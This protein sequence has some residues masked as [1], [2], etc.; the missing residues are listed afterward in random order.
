MMAIASTAAVQFDPDDISKVENVSDIEKPEFQ[1]LVNQLWRLREANKNLKYAYIMRRTSDIN[2]FEFIADADMLTA[3]E[4][5]IN[6]NGTIDPD[7]E[8]PMP[9]DPYDVTEY[10]ALRDESYYYP[11]ADRELYADQWGL[12]LAAYAPIK[13]G[14]E[15]T[16]AIIGIDVLVGDYLKLTQAT[17]LPFI[18]FVAFL[19]LLLTLLT[20]MLVRIYKERVEIMRELD[21]QK[22]EL[23]SMVSHQLAT[24][25]S[26]VKWNLEMMIDGDLGKL[27]DVQ[28]KHVKSMYAQSA[29][30]ADLAHM[31]LDVSRLQLGK[32]KVDR[33]D[34]DVKKFVEEVFDEVKPKAEEKG[35]H[36][37]KAVGGNLKNMMLDKRLMRMTMENLL[38]NAVKY[39]PKGGKVKLIAEM[40]GGA[41]HYEVSDTGCGIPK[42]DHDKIFGKL[43]RAS[44]VLN[45]DGNGFG[46]FVAKGAVEAQ[47]GSISFES[48]EGKGTVFKVDLPDVKGNTNK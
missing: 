37:E 26:A 27:T 25:I 18:L 19:V 14:N 11:V 34:L 15:N 9:G 23:L 31:I 5:D 4:E 21:R 38:T 13:D 48:K 42:K 7:E 8:L 46:L 35:V 12:M 24:P 17:L 36:Y 16:V 32:M 30:L 2:E 20:I 6:E 22:D 44:N 33:T 43:F 29:N 3:E 1:K 47:G 39:T 28:D 40:R 41:L 45:I 10:P